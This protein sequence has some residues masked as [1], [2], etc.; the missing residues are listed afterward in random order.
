MI[1]ATAAFVITIPVLGNDSL[2]LWT[3]VAIAM[4][5]PVCKLAGLYDRD[6]HL[7]HKRTLDEAP[8]IFYVATLYTLLAFLAGANIVDGTFGRAQAAVL[9]GLL[10]L[11]MLLLR[12]LA[13]RLA[14]ALVE[15]E[16]CVILGNADAAHWLATKLDR[17]DGARVEVVGR[18]PLSPD[19]TSVNE[20]PLLGHFDALEQPARRARRRPGPDRP[21]PRRQRP[22]PA[23]RDPGRQAP[24][25][26]RQR[27]AAA[28]RGGRLCLRV[29]R[30]RGRDA[31]RRAPPR[32]LALLLDHQAQLRPR[33]A[34]LLVL[35]LLAPLMAMIAV[36]IKL[37]SRG[38]VFFRQRRVGRDDEVFEIY[39]FRTMVDGR[40]RPARG[41]S[42]TATRPAAASSR[43]RTTHG[44]PA[45]AASCGAPRSMSCPSC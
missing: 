14:G 9:W 45:S 15:E 3:I 43:S 16:R 39:K 28:V 29:R 8:A 17:C 32:P 27:A 11:S 1:A 20:L 33:S 19:D 44:S 4:V 18:V 22:P 10:F 30:S 36:A 23:R 42:P 41:R 5:V 35:L 24:R 25:R 13:R 26:P 7:L 6:E 2:G 12:G 31:A 34:R 21:G 37:D 38:P 40:R